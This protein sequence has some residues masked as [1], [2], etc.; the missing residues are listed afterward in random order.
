M[1]KKPQFRYSGQASKGLNSETK[2]C[3]GK[4]ADVLFDIW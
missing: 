1:E 3:Q 4:M 2:K